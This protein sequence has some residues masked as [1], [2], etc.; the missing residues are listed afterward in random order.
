MRATSH[1]YKE[2]SAGFL[3]AALFA[4]GL[5]TSDQD[6]IRDGLTDDLI[7]PWCRIGSLD[8]WEGQ[9]CVVPLRTGSVE[10]TRPLDRAANTG[11]R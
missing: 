11:G 9:P 8:S 2:N 4:V 7:S 1:R 5:F 6:A 3:V 10:G